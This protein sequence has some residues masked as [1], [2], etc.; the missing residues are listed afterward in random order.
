[1]DEDPQ[2]RVGTLSQKRAEGELLPVDAAP[3]E[4]PS[5]Q[6]TQLAA[7]YLRGIARVRR[8]SRVR[9]REEAIR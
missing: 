1:C 9:R 5:Q 2:S 4:V 8:Q 6:S 7:G 3:Q